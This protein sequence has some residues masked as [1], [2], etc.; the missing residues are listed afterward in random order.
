MKTKLLVALFL[1]T[2]YLNSC[3][4]DEKN[5]SAK[6]DLR[7]DGQSSCEDFWNVYTPELEEKVKILTEILD[8][9]N[10]LTGEN[11]RFLKS[12]LT[13]L[14]FIPNA[15]TLLLTVHRS[16]YPIYRLKKDQVGIVGLIGGDEN[17]GRWEEFAKE[18]HLLKENFGY[19]SIDSVGVLARFPEEFA[20]L[21]NDNPP[22]FYW[23]STTGKGQSKL[24]N[25][26][27]M[28][29]DC[30]SYFHYD[31]SLNG[32]AAQE[33]LLFGSAFSLD[34]EFG[35]FPEIDKKLR[36]QYVENCM[37]CPSNYPDQK[38][39]AKLKGIEG[40]YFVYADSF[41]INTKLAVPSRSLVYQKKDGA[42]VTLWTSELD[43]SG[44]GCF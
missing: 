23:Y 17:S 12:F 41:P 15:D 3:K 43:L 31:F 35:T 18:H 6:I 7:T 16:M 13:D 38:S 29:D 24:S 4:S 2:T 33:K 20:D 5:S 32:K 8:G 21:F 44:C 19:Q 34:L 22:S 14:K 11:K 36:A 25:L 30:L 40:F 26:G 9:K 42:I 39:F 27:Y 37:D 1:L 10:D 28:G